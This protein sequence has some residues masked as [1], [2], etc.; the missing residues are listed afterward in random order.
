MDAL[1]H[2]P[3]ADMYGP[4]FLLLYS[5]VIILIMIVCGWLVQDPTKKQSLP[6][7]PSEPNPYEIAYL[8]SGTSEVVKVAILNLIQ[9]HYLQIAEKL[10]I[11]TTNPQH[12]S[13]LQPIEHQ[14]LSS[15]SSTPSIKSIA[16]IAQKVQPYCNIYEDQLHNEQL[17]YDQ[18]WQAANIKVGLIAATI[19]FILGGYKLLIALAKGRHNVGFLIIMAVLSIIFILWFV[20]RR[21]RLSFRGQAY[22]QQLQQTFAESKTKVKFS[23]PSAFDYN[24]VVALFGVEALAGTF[25]DS[26][27]K[28]FF[29]VIS[30]RT[31]SR[32]S[33]SDGSSCSGSSGCG[34][35]GS[36]CSSGSSCG[37][38]SCGGGGCGGCGG[39][40]GG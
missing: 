38:G 7:I 34:G 29:P 30:Y 9:R 8:R 25:Y 21:S 3:I 16:S 26:Y 1:I 15:F 17:L 12:S 27:Y 18:K 32:Q 40:C 37:G 24:L 35:G 4:D 5:S 19:I 39:G 13:E 14:V 28:I 10:I 2:N 23:I 22:L 11:H 6:L 20:S 36:S 33:R 31:S